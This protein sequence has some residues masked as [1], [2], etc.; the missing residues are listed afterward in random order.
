MISTAAAPTDSRQDAGAHY[1]LRF[2][3]AAGWVA[4]LNALLWTALLLR[5]TVLGSWLLAVREGVSLLPIEASLQAL[6]MSRGAFLIGAGLL[7]FAAADGVLG[8]G[9]LRGHR[10][11]RPAAFLRAAAGLG[12]C[13]A[14][15]LLTQDFVTALVLASLQG[16]ILAFLSRS[17]GLIIAYPGITF[18]IVFFLVPLLSIFAFSLGRGTALG[19]VDVSS[20]NFDN[21]LRIVSPVGRSGLVYIDTILRTVWIAFLNTA[22]CLIIAYP[23]AFWMAQQPEKRRNILMVLVMI[24]FWTNLLIRTYAWLVILRKDGLLNNLL[25]DVFGV[26]DK[27]LELTNTPVALLLGLVYGYLPFMILPLY[28]TIERLDKRYIE[29]ASDL[30]ARPTQTLWR[31]I[32]PLTMPGIV[33]GCILVFI[34]SVGTYVVTNVLG[35]GKI[36][37]I[38][39]LLEQQFMTS[40]GDKAFGAA[41]GVVLTLLMLAA[42]MIYFRLGRKEAY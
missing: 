41:F 20:P 37:L 32:F 33:A 17:A 4:L 5:G 36:Y 24:P 9:L 12:G 16:L 27:P 35:G 7:A 15:Y 34:P 11:A 23:F 18:V 30:Y 42:T 39:N 21:F 40:N 28:T 8:V 22:I 2:D 31:V 6:G 14:Y 26:I 10:L 25:I 1:R 19:T 13:L 3:R 29:A 38:G